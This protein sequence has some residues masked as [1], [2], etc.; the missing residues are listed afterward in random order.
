[1]RAWVGIDP[2]SAQ[3]ASR[4]P[5]LLGRNLVK[6][7]T[8]IPTYKPTRDQTKAATELMEHIHRITLPTARITIRSC[9]HTSLTTAAVR[10]TLLVFAKVHSTRI[11]THLLHTIAST[12]TAASRHF[13]IP[14]VLPIYNTSS[15][16]SRCNSKKGLASFLPANFINNSISTYSQPVSYEA[17][18][19]I[20]LPFP[21]VCTCLHYHP[22]WPWLR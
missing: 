1:M 10:Q 3:T 12:L 13:P 22:T 11:S 19:T 6:C 18:T 17:P 5:T 15:S 20:N 14:I 9:G 4:Q 16:A 21:T 8:A 2:P 7:S